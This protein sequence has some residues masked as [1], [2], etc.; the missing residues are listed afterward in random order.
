MRGAGE[1][2]FALTDGE[3]LGSTALEQG[4]SLQRLDGGARKDRS[5]DVTSSVQQVPV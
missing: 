5:I 4:K 2:E 3:A 1:S